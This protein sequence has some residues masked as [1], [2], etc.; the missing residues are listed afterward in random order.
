M[1]GKLRETSFQY[2]YIEKLSD[3]LIDFRLQTP[4]VEDNV[5]DTPALAI[6]FT[7]TLK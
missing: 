5:S 7:F 6:N 2:M 1:S 3:M 4:G